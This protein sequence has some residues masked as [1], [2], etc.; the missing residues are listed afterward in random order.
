MI[1][2]Y[3]GKVITIT[4]ENGDKIIFDHVFSSDPLASDAVK[5]VLSSFFSQRDS[6][7]VDD[8]KEALYTAAKAAK[9]V[10]ATTIDISNIKV[11]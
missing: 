11:K 8:S 2:N 1:I 5:F 6:Q 3:D 4:P 10:N 9:A 7:L